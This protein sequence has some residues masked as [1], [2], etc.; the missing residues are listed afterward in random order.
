MPDTLEQAAQGLL[1]YSLLFN[2]W[3]ES[4][5]AIIVCDEHKIIAVNKAVPLIFG[6]HPSEM[7]GQPVDML[8]PD[9]VKQI[10]A[11]HRARFVDSPRHRPM[12]LG[13][14][15]KGRHKDGHE[16]PVEINLNAFMEVE[17]L[18]IVGVVRRVS[19]G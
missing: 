7:I 17:G 6:Y 13:L 1:S 12:G 8:V 4:A 10:H 18:R 5:D 2:M 16:F 15:L 14:D 3:Q 9:S 19:S 11:Q